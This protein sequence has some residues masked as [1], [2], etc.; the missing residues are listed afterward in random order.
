MGDMWGSLIAVLGTLAGAVVAGILQQRAARAERA[1]ARLAERQRERVH[2][3]TALVTALVDHRRAMWL[4][5]KLRLAG[6][7]DDAYAEARAASHATRAAVTAPLVTLSVLAP[8]GR[9]R[10]RRHS[11]RLRPA[12]RRRPADPG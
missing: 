10:H 9:P 12:R 7:D 11:G 1:E 4:R 2:A 8:A 6:V 3:F 5:E